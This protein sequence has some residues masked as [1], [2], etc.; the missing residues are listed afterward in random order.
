MTQPPPTDVHQSLENAAVAGRRVLVLLQ[1][2]LQCADLNFNL[3]HFLLESV[4]LLL[5]LLQL[6]PVVLPIL[7]FLFLLDSEKGCVAFPHGQWIHLLVFD[8]LAAADPRGA[9]FRYPL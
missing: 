5:P 9:H 7:L 8:S 4:D 1:L 3:D 6:L 2:I